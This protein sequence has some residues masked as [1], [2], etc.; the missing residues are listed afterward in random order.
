M[1]FRNEV[2]RYIYRKKKNYNEFENLFSSSYLFIFVR[3]KDE[4][5]GKIISIKIF[6]LHAK[7]NRKLYIL[8]NRLSCKLFDC[9]GRIYDSVVT[10]MICQLLIT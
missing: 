2:L 6:K 8:A 10:N 5:R 3:K 7:C 4:I 1:A 9:N